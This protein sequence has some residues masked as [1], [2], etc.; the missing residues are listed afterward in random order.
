MFK[1]D[2]AVEW[3][4]HALKDALEHGSASESDLE[5]WLLAA[6]SLEEISLEDELATRQARSLGAWM[7]ASA[8]LH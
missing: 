4:I 5:D 8:T 2:D 6:I 1:T 7:S 3:L